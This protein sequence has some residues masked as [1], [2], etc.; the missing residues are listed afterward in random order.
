MLGIGKCVILSSCFDPLSKRQK[1]VFFVEEQMPGHI[2]QWDVLKNMQPLQGHNG[3]LLT[4]RDFNEYR[5]PK[6]RILVQ[7]IKS[8]KFFSFIQNS[9]DLNC[10]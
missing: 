9:S 7:N 6:T 8:D 4:M 10:I 1:L 5:I 2:S 3:I